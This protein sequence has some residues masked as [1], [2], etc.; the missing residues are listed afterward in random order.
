MLLFDRLLRI[1]TPALALSLALIALT[2][3]ASRTLV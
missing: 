2:T 3:M 1:A